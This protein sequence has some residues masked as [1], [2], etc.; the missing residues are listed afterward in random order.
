MSVTSRWVR[1]NSNVEAVRLNRAEIHKIAFWCGGAIM[2][3]DTGG[4]EGNG[5]L[6][7]LLP[8]KSNYNKPNRAFMGDWILKDDDGF[9]VYSHEAFQG[10][11]LKKTKDTEKFAEILKLVKHAMSEQDVA[12]YFAG[13]GKVDV[14]L[15]AK[16]VS[17]E[18]LEL[19]A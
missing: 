7:I 10:V 12:A 4:R 2:A 13:E 1:K 6:F 19:F 17:Q 14:A 5:A 16:Q 8:F 9:K 3:T 18:I 11:F 15:V